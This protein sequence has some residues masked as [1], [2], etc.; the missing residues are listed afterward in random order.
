MLCKQSNFMVPWRWWLGN[1]KDIWLMKTCDTYLSQRF[2]SRARDAGAVAPEEPM[3][4]QVFGLWHWNGS[5]LHQHWRWQN[6]DRKCYFPVYFLIRAF[7]HQRKKINFIEVHASGDLCSQTP[8]TLKDFLRLWLEQVKEGNRGAY[9][10][11]PN[12]GSPDELPMNSGGDSD[13]SDFTR[14]AVK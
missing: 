8:P 14:D 12:Q 9:D 4:H 2:S 5:I 6:G 11:P 10:Q 3:L 7:R 1:R 13:D